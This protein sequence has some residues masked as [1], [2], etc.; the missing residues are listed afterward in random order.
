MNILEFGRENNNISRYRM[1]DINPS[2]A[3]QHGIILTRAL[4]V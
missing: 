4:Y 3:C 2:S 1:K